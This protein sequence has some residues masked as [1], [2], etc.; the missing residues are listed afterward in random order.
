MYCS[1]SCLVVNAYNEYM[2]ATVLIP[3]E[4]EK[5]PELKKLLA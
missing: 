1:Q 2:A 4:E 3:Y 5:R